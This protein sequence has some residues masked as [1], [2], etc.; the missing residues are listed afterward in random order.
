MVIKQKDYIIIGSD[1]RHSS[2]MGINS[3]TMSKIFIVDGFIMSTTGFYADSYEV[4]TKLRYHIKMYESENRRKISMASAAHLLHNILYSKRF[5]PYYSF[6]TFS[7]YV[8]TPVVYGY[9][10]VGSYESVVCDCSGSSAPLIQPILDSVV[11]KKNWAN[12]EMQDLGV[13][14]GIKVVKMAFEAAAERDVNTG[15]YLEIF[16]MRRDGIEKK[17]FELRKD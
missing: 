14:E 6:I 2:E 12:C 10:P 16:V 3:R 13:D 1:T 4:F 11:S 7:G 15:D 9:D 5:F 8:E 17:I